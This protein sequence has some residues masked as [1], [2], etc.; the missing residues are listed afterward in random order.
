M[1]EAVTSRRIIRVSNR[2]MVFIVVAAGS[3]P[4]RRCTTRWIC[5]HHS[6]TDSP[7]REAGARRPRSAIT[8]PSRRTSMLN[9]G[10]GI[11]PP[12]SMMRNTHHATSRRIGSGSCDRSTPARQV[13][14]WQNAPANSGDTL[15]SAKH[16]SRIDSGTPAHKSSSARGSQ[17]PRAASTNRSWPLRARRSRAG[18]DRL[19]AVRADSPAR[20]ERLPV[21]DRPHL[22]VTSVTCAY[23]F[24][25][26]CTSTC[27]NRRLTTCT[28][29]PDNNSAVA[30]ECRIQCGDQACGT[31]PDSCRRSR[32]TRS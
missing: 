32:S 22:G 23:V 19:V 27:P 31:C 11:F 1:S 28:G 15:D 20:G 9:P 18:P 8:S 3:R 6:R 24:S 17:R 5:W 7:S 25:V 30:C 16:D 4:L 13:P 21:G 10:V 29:T 2:R 26:V 12:N 14:S